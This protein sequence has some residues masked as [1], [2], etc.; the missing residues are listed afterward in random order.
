MTPKPRRVSSSA[1]IDPAVSC[2]ILIAPNEDE[3]TRLSPRAEV[4]AR[5]RLWAL[6]E[7]A[8]IMDIPA[9]L[10]SP[11]P[12]RRIHS[13]VARVPRVA[14]HHQFL[15]G[16]DEVPWCNTTFVEML[17]RINNSVLVVAGYWMEHEILTTALNARHETYY[18]Y[19][20]VDAAPA[21]TNRDSALA[22]ER[23]LQAGATPVLT[24]HV[25]REWRLEAPDNAKRAA[26]SSALAPIA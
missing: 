8:D 9:L 21:R 16:Q 2:L 23:L 4:D 14:S 11:G 10:V 24:S 6:A 19:V 3:L 17:D 26:L 20:P 1:L 15:I 25:L 13:L 7:A 12:S 18:V 5:R 22:C